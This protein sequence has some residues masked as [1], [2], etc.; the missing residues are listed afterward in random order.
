MITVA[1]SQARSVLRLLMVF[2][3]TAV[4]AGYQYFLVFGRLP[5]VALQRSW[6]TVTVSGSTT[7]AIHG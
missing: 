5:G 4:Y 6:D 3:S 7:A 1:F 2:V